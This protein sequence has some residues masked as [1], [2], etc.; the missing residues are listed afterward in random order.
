[1]AFLD[2]R[3]TFKADP[4]QFEGSASLGLASN[5]SSDEEPTSTSSTLTSGLDLSAYPGPVNVLADH[6]DMSTNSIVCEGEAIADLI[7]SLSAHFRRYNQLFIGMQSTLHE[8]SRRCSERRQDPPQ[9]LQDAHCYVNV[10]QFSKKYCA[11]SPRQA[12]H[13]QISQVVPY[14]SI[15]LK[16]GRVASAQTA[17]RPLSDFN[18]FCRD[19]RKLVVEAHPEYTKE[20]VNKEL[21]RIWST[22]DS[23][24][25]QHYRQMYVQDKLRYS[26]DITAL[27]GRSKNQ[28]DSSYIVGSMH[29]PLAAI[30]I[31][32][33][34]GA[35]SSAANLEA[36]DKAKQTIWKCVTAQV[37]AGNDH[38]K[39][40]A[41]TGPEMRAGGTKDNMR[42]KDISSHVNIQTQALS[43]HIRQRATAPGKSLQSILNDSIVDDLEDGDEPLARSL[44]MTTATQYQQQLAT[45]LPPIT[46]QRSGERV[47]LQSISTANSSSA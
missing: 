35:Q 28:T 22:L 13:N 15:S 18:F 33:E 43:D 21:G 17:K 32:S 14:S 31:P 38:A 9:P 1:M 40:R 3:D 25:R 39:Y 10:Q 20:Q 8:L 5:T 29:W 45:K 12:H 46:P 2:A 26:Q 24:S 30:G 27:A 23:T 42:N 34:N 41:L 44:F 36:S 11:N 37:S 19:A 47:Q 4:A 7:A 6:F 16:H